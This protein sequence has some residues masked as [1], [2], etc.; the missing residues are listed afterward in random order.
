MGGPSLDT[1][2][3]DLHVYLND[4]HRFGF[5]AYFTPQLPRF[6]PDLDG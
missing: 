1:G 5:G 4:T 3:L 2:S 6:V